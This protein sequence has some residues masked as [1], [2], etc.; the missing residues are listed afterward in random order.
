MR[1][2]VKEHYEKLEAEKKQLEESQDSANIA[3]SIFG[4]NQ[5]E[6]PLIQEEIVAPVKAPKKTK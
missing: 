4:D 6:T 3:R 2:Q 5:T 1:K